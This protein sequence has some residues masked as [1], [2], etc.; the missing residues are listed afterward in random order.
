MIEAQFADFQAVLGAV[1]EIRNR[2]NIPMKEELQFSVR[3]DAA[4]AKLLAPMEPYFAQMARAT[5]G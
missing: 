3:C 4:T 5:A 2:Q 1:R